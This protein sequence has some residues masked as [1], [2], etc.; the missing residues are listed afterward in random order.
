MNFASI[1]IERLE[2]FKM[3]LIG[4]LLT[5]MMASLNSLGQ[6]LEKI[7]VEKYYVAEDHDTTAPLPWR[8]LLR[9]ENPSKDLF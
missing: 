4:V 9:D 5:M 3:L 1:S 6:G 8:W 7:I 2:M